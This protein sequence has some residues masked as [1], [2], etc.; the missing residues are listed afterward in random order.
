MCV[1]GN[2]RTGERNFFARVLDGKSFEE[3]AVNS[4][5]AIKGYSCLLP[6]NQKNQGKDGKNGF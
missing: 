5:W 6:C 3:L 1:K 4:V 2:H